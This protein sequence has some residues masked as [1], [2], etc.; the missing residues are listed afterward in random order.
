MVMAQS[1][2]KYLHQQNDVTIDVLAP[3]WV[4]G[5]VERMPEVRHGIEFDSRHGKLDLSMRI[6]TGLK[7][8]RQRYDEAIVM[9]RSL[10]SAIPSW[11]AGISR[12]TGFSRNLGLLNNVRSYEKAREELF[13]RRYLALAADDAYSIDWNAIPRP[14]LTVDTQNRQQLLS[15]FGLSDGAFVAIAP[16]AEFGPAK[17][18][19]MQRLAELSDRLIKMGL[20]VVIVGSHKEQALANQIKALAASDDL[21]DLCGQT[22]V[23][24]VVDLASAS[25]SMV[26]N[27]SGLMHL[28]YAAGARIIAIYGSSSSRYTPPLAESAVILE[29]HLEC[30]P[31]FERQCRFGHYDCLNGI[32]AE[33]VLS[34]RFFNNQDGDH[35]D[36]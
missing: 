26:V 8:R 2:F 19:P 29:Q 25:H 11:V 17:Q 34:S 21:I 35:V 10:K 28:G 18:W 24:D 15:R 31:C 33:D 30:Q 22:Q 20:Q 14:A 13:V 32:G 1:L 23:A 27:D 36:S 3:K 6:Q 7:L 9:P 5:L 4:I 16:G 12:R